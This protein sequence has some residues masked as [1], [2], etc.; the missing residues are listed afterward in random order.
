M[1]HSANMKQSQHDDEYV[2]GDKLI[3]SITYEDI[4]IYMKDCEDLTPKEFSNDELVIIQECIS[5]HTK[6]IWTEM[7]HPAL[8]EALRLIELKHKLDDIKEKHSK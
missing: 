7:I 1:Y 6:H 2:D 4:S 5:E 3:Y 8:E